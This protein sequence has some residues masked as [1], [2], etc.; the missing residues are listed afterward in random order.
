[1]NREIDTHQGR[2]Q[3]AVLTSSVGADARRDPPP[4]RSRRRL[5]HLLLLFWLF[6]AAATSSAIADSETEQGI[7]P[8]KPLALQRALSFAE[9]HPRTRISDGAMLFPR[10][11]PLFL[12]CHAFTFGGTRGGD[13]TR[14]V[15]W[16]PLLTP[17]DQQRLEIMQRFFDVLLAD[18]SFSRDNEAMAVAYIQF[19]RAAARAELGQFSPLK[20]AELEAAFQL[21]RRQRAASESAQLIT[22]S[23]LA[24]ALAHPEDL[25]RDLITPDLDGQK[26]PLPELDNVIAEAMNKNPRITQLLAERTD[27]EQVLIEMELRQQAVE[28]LARLSLLEVI[29]EQTRAESNWRDLKLDESRTLYELE[30][31]AD[32]G[33]SMSQQTKARRDQEQVALCAALA[34]AELEALQGRPVR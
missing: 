24:Q 34:L 3:R 19:D 16:S 22:R 6:G 15:A 31:K 18:L 5:T 20:V 11:Q 29:A 7:D 10:R 27:A 23:L 28:L 1:M 17:K 13:Q 33:F 9:S 2:E 26:A 30:A 8:S 4:R 21:I 32:L 25:P 12:A 14:D